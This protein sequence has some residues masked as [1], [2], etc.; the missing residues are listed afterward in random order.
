MQ[1][2]QPDSAVAG[3]GAELSID[4]VIAMSVDDD[5]GLSICGGQLSAI[6]GHVG[7]VVWG[8]TA[9]IIPYISRDQ[10]PTAAYG[11]LQRPTEGLE[12]KRPAVGKPQVSVR[13]AWWR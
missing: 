5:G 13:K 1:F 12:S 10:G 11:R 4:L 7:Q 6:G 8:N 2:E 9:K 3:R